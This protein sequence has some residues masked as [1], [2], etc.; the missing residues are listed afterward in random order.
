[1]DTDTAILIKTAPAWRPEAGDTITGT[2]CKILRMSTQYGDYPKVVLQDTAADGSVNYLAWHAMHQT[3]LD[4]LKKAKPAP[5]D[6]ITVH[7]GGRIPSKKRVDSDG[8][9]VKY[10]AWTI[11]TE[12]DEDDTFDLTDDAPGF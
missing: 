11:V 9:P 8:K 5:G 1:M 2:V 3:A 4:A 7:Y 6:T 10:H 12:N